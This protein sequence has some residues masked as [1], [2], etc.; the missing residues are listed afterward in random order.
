LS[1][2][3]GVL[4]RQGR[5]LAIPGEASR[6]IA[7]IKCPDLTLLSLTSSSFASMNDIELKT[8]IKMV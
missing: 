2:A 6:F 8:K 5:A 1:V 7:N 4:S 3:K